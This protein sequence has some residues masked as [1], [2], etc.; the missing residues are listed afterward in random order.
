MPRS[1]MTE[2]VRGYLQRLA[3]QATTAVPNNI[4]AC[5]YISCS[6]RDQRAKGVAGGDCRRHCLSPFRKLGLVTSAALCDALGDFYTRNPNLFSTPAPR[7]PYNALRLQFVC[8]CYGRQVSEGLSGNIPSAFFI[9]CL[10]VAFASIAISAQ[11]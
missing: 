10:I 5:P 9:H 11:H 2:L 4:P 6:S 7:Y 1:I 8:R 3:T